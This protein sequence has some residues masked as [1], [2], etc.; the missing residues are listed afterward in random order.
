MILSKEPKIAGFPDALPFS[1]K[2]R[3]AWKALYQILAAMASLSG[4]TY[5]QQVELKKR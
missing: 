4:N 5:S 3:L 1:K 2:K